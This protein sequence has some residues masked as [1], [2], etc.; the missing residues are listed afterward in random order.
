MDATDTAV[1]IT[2]NQPTTM[3]IIIENQ[4]S[5]DTK[6][7]FI[8][9]PISSIQ[10]EQCQSKSSQIDAKISIQA[11][12]GF[13]THHDRL[14]ATY[15][16]AHCNVIS[17]SASAAPTE[18][19]VQEAQTGSF[20]KS[21][22]AQ[23]ADSF[24]Q[25]LR[26]YPRA[27]PEFARSSEVIERLLSSTLAKRLSKSKKSHTKRNKKCHHEVPCL[28]KL[29]LYPQRQRIPCDCSKKAAQVAMNVQ[30]TTSGMSTPKKQLT[31]FGLREMSRLQRLG[32]G[33][34]VRY[35]NDVRKCIRDA[36][37]HVWDNDAMVCPEIERRFLQHQ[38]EYHNANNDMACE[39]FC[40]GAKSPQKGLTNTQTEP[41]KPQKNEE[42]CKYCHKC[43]K[44]IPCE[45]PK[46][47]IKDSPTN[48]GSKVGK[49]CDRSTS[50][51]NHMNTSS[52]CHLCK[53]EQEFSGQ[54]LKQVIDWQQE[55]PLNADCSEEDKAKRQKVIRTL[56][57][58][59][60]RFKGMED[61]QKDEIKKALD[62]MPMWRPVD[63]NDREM[64]INNLIENL[65]IRMSLLKDGDNSLK[66][67]V[68]DWIDKFFFKQKTLDKRVVRKDNILNKFMVKIATLK[69]NE[70]SDRNE[71]NEAVRSQVTDLFKKLL[72]PSPDVNFVN[73]AA[74]ELIQE[75]NKV[76]SK[77][78][79][80]LNRKYG[81]SNEITIPEKSKALL[82]V[83]VDKFMGNG[84]HVHKMTAQNRV[85]DDIKKI[86]E[87]TKT[88]NLDPRTE[89][90]LMEALI[91]KVK[92]LSSSICC[93]SDFIS[94]NS[95][96]NSNMQQIIESKVKQVVDQLPLA[97]AHNMKSVLK[98]EIAD[99]IS[100][101]MG[102]ES[103]IKLPKSLKEE[104]RNYV[105]ELVVGV[106]KANAGDVSNQKKF[107]NDLTNLIADQI[108]RADDSSNFKEKAYTVLREANLS[109]N[110]MEDVYNSLLRRTIDMSLSFKNKMHLSSSLLRDETAK[111]RQDQFNSKRTENEVVS[112]ISHI[113][114][115][116]NSNLKE[117]LM[118]SANQLADKMEK[119]ITD[120]KYSTKEKEEMLSKLVFNFFRNHG[121]P[122]D[123]SSRHRIKKWIK[124][125]LNTPLGASTPKQML[126]ENYNSSPTLSSVQQDDHHFK[127][128]SQGSLVQIYENPSLNIISHEV[129]KCIERI[130]SGRMISHDKNYHRIV[131]KEIA[132]RLREA[133][134]QSSNP[135]TSLK[136][137]VI[138]WLPKLVKKPN[139]TEL[140]WMTS[141]L[142]KI[143]EDKELSDF[144]TRP[145]YQRHY[146]GQAPGT[147]GAEYS[148][149]CT[150]AFK[151]AI[152]SWLK[153]TSLYQNRNI[154]EK[155]FQENLVSDLALD[156]NRVI[157]DTEK[158]FNDDSI[159]KVLE[160]KIKQFPMDAK[161]KCDKNY[162][163]SLALEVLKYL[164][165]AQLIPSHNSSSLDDVTRHVLRWIE[166]IP[167][168]RIISQDVKHQK[169]I[170]K[171]IAKRVLETKNQNQNPD[172]ALECE[173]LRW[174]PKIVKEPTETEL[175][176][177][178]G[179]LKKIVNYDT[180]IN[181][182]LTETSQYIDALKY[183][184]MN[185]LKGS[186]M[187]HRRNKQEEICQET[188]MENL[189]VDLD[190]IN[191]NL[192]PNQNIDFE[193]YILKTIGSRLKELP[194]NP[195]VKN[196][197][198]YN[199]TM[200]IDLLNY[201]KDLNML[202]SIRKTPDESKKNV[203]F[204]IESL[205]LKW[206][207]STHDA[208]KTADRIYSI[209]SDYLDNDFGSA[210]TNKHFKNV[211]INVLK[212]LPLRDD[213]KNEEKL[214]ILVEHLFII[215]KHNTK[216][217]YG[218]NNSVNV[219][220][221][222]NN[223]TNLLA[224]E[225]ANKCAYIPIDSA[226]GPDD[227]RKVREELV[228]GLVNIVN[229]ENLNYAWRN[230]DTFYETIIRNEVGQLL[231]NL[232]VN[233]HCRRN[234]LSFKNYLVDIMKDVFSM[235]QKEKF[236]T[237]YRQQLYD[238]IENTLPTNT[239][240]SS[241]Q[242]TS[243]NDLKE[244][245][246]EAFVTLFKTTDVNT[247]RF[248]M[249][250]KNEVNKFCN[251][252]LR[253]YPATPLDTDKLC[254]NLFSVLQNIRIP[255]KT[256]N[257]S[258]ETNYTKNKIKDYLEE[259][260]L[261]V[262]EENILLRNHFV[263][264]IQHYLENPLEIQH[265]NLRDKITEKLKQFTFL[266][267][268]KPNL[269]EITENI[270]KI[271][272]NNDQMNKAHRQALQQV[273]RTLHS[274]NIRTVEKLDKQT[275]NI[276][277]DAKETF[278]YDAP[279]EDGENVIRDHFKE[280]FRE[281]IRYQQLN[282]G[283]KDVQVN[284]PPNVFENQIN[285]R[286]DMISGK[287]RSDS[288][289]CSEFNCCLPK[290]TDNCLDTLTCQKHIKTK[291]AQTEKACD[292]S[293][294]IIVKEYY[295]DSN[296][297]EM[298]GSHQELQGIHNE[299]RRTV[300]SLPF[301]KV[302]LPAPHCR[303]RRQF[304]KSPCIS[305]ISMAEANFP[306]NQSVEEEIWASRKLPVTRYR[307]SNISLGRNVDR[308]E[309]LVKP[310]SESKTK[311]QNFCSD[312]NGYSMY[313]DERRRSNDYC[314]TPELT[315]RSSVTRPHMSPATD[316]G[317]SLGQDRDDKK[318]C[319]CYG[320]VHQK[321]IGGPSPD[322]SGVVSHH[323]QCPSNINNCVKCRGVICHHPSYIYFN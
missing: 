319:N 138:R 31:D 126:N 267:E 293:P 247:G 254:D 257:Y 175:H 124:R 7:R 192:P 94:D 83:N 36:I 88:N 44:I 35:L 55:I 271:L 270:L 204:W 229:K 207:I 160:T 152:M 154:H 64:F 104:I 71:Y 193:R 121:L 84:N 5:E 19:P 47:L 118:I 99:V 311:R 26:K 140:I 323:S 289:S 263:N 283:N 291:C 284:G 290:E 274:T 305:H 292:L 240:L 201:L 38:K 48:L 59:L 217:T 50:L 168:D 218:T 186:E 180:S 248:K 200:A 144:S 80:T 30:P 16:I 146:T 105:K 308:A 306:M 3:H 123:D 277:K 202:R 127:T 225:L 188:V 96:Q 128:M 93:N 222:G 21:R 304:L 137:T 106:L 322:S 261:K 156:L 185:W 23:V 285:A 184:L 236:I 251:D 206:T 40:I 81:T 243:F 294:R 46:P 197:D 161:E 275:S 108:I 111:K 307:Q 37:K 74:D 41:E 18:Y 131:A 242:Q 27:L 12:T 172:L 61:K 167:R 33:A 43:K 115:N 253:R 230:G 98:D 231:N 13:Q 288:P 51:E 280:S 303:A 298:V 252:Y 139:E 109:T 278:T 135:E 82:D 190:R 25:S 57:K 6:S 191:N 165:D 244:K 205:P 314:L 113:S 315:E 173:V 276:N 211:V 107:Q 321:I 227:A 142:K 157:S 272:Y 297:N 116:L 89:S 196:T 119:I 76:L 219:A 122:I 301:S 42:A 22:V 133:A 56:V 20:R 132:Q 68:N 216:E 189:A 125:I 39:T 45:C 250:L 239:T 255:E 147:P 49:C 183:A 62:T 67:I 258:D 17:A 313:E 158:T 235:K 9:Q 233:E 87:L 153:E 316:V 246:V 171:E 166:K 260:P 238:I 85:K 73:K 77:K 10:K 170:A 177:L 95:K 15:Q 164:K 210:N 1:S 266:S 279:V 8:I 179:N 176:G 58:S 112:F 224:T 29:H 72:V 60:L 155:R 208:R 182:L 24:A 66:T 151:K 86:I 143:M 2:N 214:E 268:H 318:K 114:S 286:P 245:L 249:V 302:D 78:S 70:K 159:L 265:T 237:N 234:L 32:R 299:L 129:V 163:R 309:I 120:V 65:I 259:L 79:D 141:I 320:Y 102:V 100:Q 14:V 221:S 312:Q 232:K 174:L 295:W 256:P 103:S 264:L 97:I 281:Y 91:M 300:P 150:E 53:E 92:A 145:A 198:N 162:H 228:S 273:S 148:N 90:L 296:D 226:Q 310:I 75:L 199:Y 149:Q 101:K 269:P 178:K 213:F 110:E 220:Y 241:D 69:I 130:P 169:A 11:S 287:N 223:S 134:N 63:S 4:P 187:Y 209:L 262:T 28:R 203:A 215:L 195:R 194:L 282:T 54:L 212:D 136:Q 52:C 117:K 34:E 181:N 317:Y